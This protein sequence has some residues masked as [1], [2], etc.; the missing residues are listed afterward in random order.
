[1]SNHGLFSFLYLSLALSS[2]AL[3]GKAEP[4]LTLTHSINLISLWG[5]H[6][7]YGPEMLVSRISSRWRHL[8]WGSNN[9]MTSETERIAHNTRKR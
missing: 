5:I 2:L 7:G 8:F 9:D 3:L 6:R 4:L 1:M